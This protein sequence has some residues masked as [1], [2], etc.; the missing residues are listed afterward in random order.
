MDNRNHLS[1]D[2][3]MPNFAEKRSGAVSDRTKAL[4]SGCEKDATSKVVENF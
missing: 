3:R 1:F 4:G 2:F